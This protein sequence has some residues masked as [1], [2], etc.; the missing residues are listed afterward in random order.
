MSRLT[1]GRPWTRTCPIFS[2]SLFSLFSSSFLSLSFCDFLQTLQSFFLLL[3]PFLQLFLV[4]SQRPAGQQ[5]GESRK[6]ERTQQPATESIQ[7]ALPRRRRRRR[8]KKSNVER[9][10]LKVFTFVYYQTALQQQPDERYIKTRR[11]IEC[12][13]A[14][15]IYIYI[16]IYFALCVIYYK[17]GEAAQAQSSFGT[18][19]QYVDR[20][21]GRGGCSQNAP[22]FFFLPIIAHLYLV[23]LLGGSR[24]P[25]AGCD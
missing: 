16:Y 19:K 12:E 18:R 11:R 13:H 8:R 25:C 15:S 9:H 23:S 22:I 24:A 7:I 6:H 4:R 21:A 14:W 20:P 5:Q 2:F 3:L 10:F 17:P 1:Q